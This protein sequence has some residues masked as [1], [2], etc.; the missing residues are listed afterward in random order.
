MPS[1]H[2]T[3]VVVVV[4][5]VLGVVFHFGAVDVLDL[6][7]GTPVVEVGA[8]ATTLGLE[9]FTILL[10]AFAITIFFV[11]SLSAVVIL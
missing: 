10:L 3:P 11:L 9:V 4:L 7:F 1:F 5:L 2:F 6:T 8:P